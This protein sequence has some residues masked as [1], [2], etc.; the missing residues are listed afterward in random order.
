LQRVT[1][2][3]RIAGRPP[4]HAPQPPAVRL[5]LHLRVCQVSAKA[6]RHGFLPSA[7][8]RELALLGSNLTRC[9][10]SEAAQPLHAP[11][12]SASVVPPRRST[13]HYCATMGPARACAALLILSPAVPQHVLRTLLAASTR[14][15]CS[16]H[17]ASQGC[18]WP[19]C[20]AVLSK[21]SCVH[22]GLCAVTPTLVT[23]AGCSNPCSLLLLRRCLQEAREGSSKCTWARSS[24]TKSSFKERHKGSS[25]RK[26]QGRRGGRG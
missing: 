15:A 18:E 3:A 8:A 26:Q 9:R 21:G 2:M 19:P 17:P 5:P 16:T 20:H 23:T 12:C 25:G 6:G 1:A 4:V 11:V 24:A 10:R 14:R 22:A 7:K 13:C